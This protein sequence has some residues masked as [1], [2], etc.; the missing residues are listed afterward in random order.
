M[1]REEGVPDKYTYPSLIKA[2]SSAREV[3]LGRAIHGSA[4]RNG[5]EGDAYVRTSLI[6]LYGKCREIVCARRVFDDMT[7]KNV[8]SWTAMVV[9]YVTVGDLAEAKGLFDV[10]PQRNI[11]SWNAIISGLVRLGDLRGA[12]RIFDE[13]PEKNAVS[14]T[15]MIDGYAK[16]GDMASAR[17]LFEQV[18]VR[19]IVAWSALISGY[20]QN[21][22]PNEAV[23]V[24][25]EMESRDVKPDEFVLVSLMSACSQVG[26][27]D[28]AKWV[29]SYLSRSAIDLRQ[30]HIAAALIELNAKC[31]NMERAAKLFE[32]MPQKDLFSYCSMIQGLSYHG[33]GNRAVGLFDRMLNEGLVPDEVAFTVILT[34]CSHGGLVEEG[35]HYFESMKN[36]YSI[37]PSPNHYACMVDLLSRSGRLKAAYELIKTMPVEPHAGAWGA[38]LGAC[39][40]HCDME[41]GEVIAAR[42]LELEPLNSGNYVLLSNI[43]A[44]AGRWLDVSLVRK[45]MR[46]RGVRKIAG[47]SLI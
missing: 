12:K 23:K 42:L 38:L 13:M 36:K 39:K 31:G 15:T 14:Y 3:R 35:W 29:D 11:V 40:E 43:Y 25:L 33:H 2:C 32:E 1:K 37:V 9:G 30:P 24:F 16:A 34:A 5:A 44:A 18:P 21:G 17:F 8:V 10:M 41:L 6:D 20:A 45:K 4:L 22:E 27:L 26:S 7:E 46:E 47:Y 19:D 28:L